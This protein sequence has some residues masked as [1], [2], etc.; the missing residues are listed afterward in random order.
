MLEHG[1]VRWFT[2]SLKNPGVIQKI[3]LES[4]DNA[5]A[6]TFVAITTEVGEGGAKNDS[7]KTSSAKFEWGNHPRVLIVGG[8]ASHDFDRWFNQADVAALSAKASVNYTED[9]SRIGSALKDIDVLYLSNNKPIAGSELREQIFSFVD[10]GKPLLL[11]HPAL[12]Y[13]WND[14]PEYNRTLVGG[15]SR[16]HE[17]YGEFEVTVNEPNHPI[18]GGVPNTFKISD[19]LYQH[20]QDANGTPIQVLATGKSLV[21]GKTYPVVWI[22][23]HPKAKV[24]CITL[25]HDGA[26]HDLAAYKTILNNS[27]SWLSQKSK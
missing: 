25:G 27:V 1:Q 24:V 19:E 20:V 15:G 13:N 8:G 11:L 3:T 23:K 2:R 9:I 7:P 22:T 12:W 6:P 5:V 14:W 10:A 16:G 4:F 17:K 18:M 26:A 21:T